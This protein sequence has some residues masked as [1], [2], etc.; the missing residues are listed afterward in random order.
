MLC[1]MA[2]GLYSSE[3]SLVLRIMM[4]GHFFFTFFGVDEEFFMLHASRSRYLLVRVY[5][6]FNQASHPFLRYVSIISLI[7]PRI[8]RDIFYAAGLIPFLIFMPSHPTTNFRDVS[9]WQKS[10]GVR[11]LCLI[12]CYAS[13]LYDSTICFVSDAAN[14]EA[15]PS[16]LM[17][18]YLRIEVDPFV[19]YPVLAFVNYLPS[20]IVA[21]LYV[22]VFR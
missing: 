17:Q 6:E 15:R 3:C 13:L 18:W 2:G 16:F 22:A 21:G 5:V 8:S 14:A 20:V 1:Y 4:R 12:F 11:L 7:L 10:R 9:T 19:R